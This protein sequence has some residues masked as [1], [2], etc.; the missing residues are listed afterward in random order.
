MALVDFGKEDQ[1]P[2]EIHSTRE[3]LHYLQAIKNHNELVCLTV[4]ESSDT[5]LTSILYVSD[6]DDMTVVLDGAHTTREN[7]R[8]AA[9]PEVNFSVF[10][11]HIKILF[12][13]DN[14]RECT[15]DDRPA[16][17]INRPTKFIR[18]QRREFYRV[19]TPVTHPVMC[20]LPMLDSDGK[21]TTLSLPLT[22]ISCGGIALRDDKQLLR[23]SIGQVYENCRLEMQG[24]VINVNLQVQNSMEIKTSNN[25]QKRRVGCAF[26]NTQNATLAAVQRYIM[27]LEAEQRSRIRGI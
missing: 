4:A 23:E 25:I 11:D 17:L 20:H 16:F 21:K 6:E 26:I 14:V 22:D 8:I 12:S 3:I 15:Y 13:S 1:S 5:L 19:S 10:L 7:E 18:L 27:K 9:S 24:T 2:F